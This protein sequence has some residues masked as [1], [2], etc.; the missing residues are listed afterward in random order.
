VAAAVAA[1]VEEVAFPEKV[2]PVEVG[3]RLAENHREALSEIETFNLSAA[4][5]GKVEATSRTARAL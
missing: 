4:V 3:F 5:A 2:Q 1:A